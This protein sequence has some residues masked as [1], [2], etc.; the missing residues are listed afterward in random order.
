MTPR[1]WLWVRWPVF[2]RARQTG[3]RLDTSAARPNPANTDANTVNTDVNT[4]PAS[5]RRRVSVVNGYMHIRA[6][7]QSLTRA[8]WL[9]PVRV[10]AI[11]DKT[12]DAR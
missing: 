1:A 2:E 9:T 8:R 4:L 3:G 11:T 5:P 12:G 10:T 7:G 6:C